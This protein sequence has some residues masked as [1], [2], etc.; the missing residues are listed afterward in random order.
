[1]IPPF[2]LQGGAPLAI[3]RGL[4]VAGWLSVTGALAFRSLVLPRA[5]AAAPADLRGAVGRRLTVLAQASIAAA[6][7][8]TLAWLVLAAG[9]MAD[10][11]SAR[12]A[13]AA[14]PAV[15]RT[16]A[17]G[18]VTALQLAALPLLAAVIG[19]RGVPGIRQHAAFGLA[20]AALCLQ[21][22]HSHAAAME[23]GPGLLLG[24]DVLHLLG[25]A[26]WLG[27]L[28]PLLIVVRHAPPRLGAL[29]ARWFS[30]LGQCCI[31]LLVASAAVQGW[32][33]VG[34]LPGLVGT[35]YGWMVLV[36]AALFAVLLGFA[37]ANRYR[38]APALL[39]G[40]HRR[41]LVR[42][43]AL[44]TG[45]ALAIV[46]AAIVLSGLPP[47]M[48]LQ[49]IWPFSRRPDFAAVREDPDFLREVVLAGLALAAG[50]AVLGAAVL[51]RRFRLPVA[52]FAAVIAWCAIPHFDLLLADATP[53]SYFRSPT[54]FAADSIAAGAALYGS[55]CAICHG[56]TG[57]GDGKLA[58]TLAVP[59]ANLTA[60]HVLMHDDGE[61]FGWLTEGIR[62]AEGAQVMPGFAS[63]LDETAR[64]ALIDFVR[65][66]NQGAALRTEGGWR[67]P[68][69]APG[70]QLQCGDSARQLAD[71]DA[72]FVRLVIGAAPAGAA[73]PGL[74]SP[75]GTLPGPAGG[76]VAG[77]AAVVAAYA[78]LAGR[79]PA[80]LAGA[81]FLIDGAGWLRAIQLPGA[82][83][84]WDAAGALSATLL[85][86]RQHPVS[87][88]PVASAPAGMHMDMKM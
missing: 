20:A 10:A 41:V 59:P 72:S 57:L 87:P 30:P 25:A 24:M 29:A 53:E 80:A 11:D 6:F 81:Q 65:A 71:L 70:F 64:W 5:F 12:A 56:A 32:V 45:A 58:R 4:A 1:M 55:N 69:R 36:K 78:I 38:F 79:E 8:A 54:G 48:H 68:L 75:I 47:A 60:A 7:V 15:L 19:L 14:V 27:G 84:G 67:Q 18:H 76:C 61:M 17:F 37:A 2:D 73:T 16:T 43:I 9:G 62:S 13:F 51:R 35:A 22:G 50:L 33:L 86:L 42:S 31:L 85:A 21:A 66:H 46:A 40:D 28:I 52:A 44:Q 23:G 39:R 77:D 34:S 74:V 83:P 49:P 82:A 63:R 88:A 26:G 3:A